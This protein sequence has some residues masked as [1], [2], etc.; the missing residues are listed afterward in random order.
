MG[1]SSRSDCQLCPPGYA[2]LVE[3]LISPY[4]PLDTSDVNF[5]PAGYYCL[6]GTDTVDVSDDTL[7]TASITLFPCPAGYECPSGKMVKMICEPGK[8]QNQE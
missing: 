6:Y 2:C 5:C 3:G 7:V 8:Y 4:E 1:A